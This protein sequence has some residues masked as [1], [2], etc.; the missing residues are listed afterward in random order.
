MCWALVRQELGNN[1]RQPRNEDKNTSASDVK[2]SVEV[3]LLI[4]NQELPEQAGVFAKSTT[5]SSMADAADAFCQAAG[6]RA[7]GIGKKKRV[8]E[9]ELSK[10]AMAFVLGCSEC[11]FFGGRPR[12]HRHEIDISCSDGVVLRL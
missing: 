4:G 8:T 2:K 6:H 5:D 10:S 9:S 1:L 7:G 3:L 11:A 12:C